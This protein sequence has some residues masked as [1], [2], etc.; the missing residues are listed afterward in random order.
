LSWKQKFTSNNLLS[1]FIEMKTARLI[2]AVGEKE[3]QRVE[4]GGWT[5]IGLKL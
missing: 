3:A 5:G 2:R 1:V 4:A